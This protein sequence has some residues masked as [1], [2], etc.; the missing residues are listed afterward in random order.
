MPCAAYVCDANDEKPV[1][2]SLSRAAPM[3]LLVPSPKL[4]TMPADEQN[5]TV[6]GA[7]PEAGDAVN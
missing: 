7:G 2:Q 5:F 6:N 1:G 4:I 3:P